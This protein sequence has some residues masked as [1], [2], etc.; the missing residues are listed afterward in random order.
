MYKEIQVSYADPDRH[1]T[2]SM[3]S[4]SIFDSEESLMIRY[5]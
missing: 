1:V 4:M 3:K 5:E 2:W